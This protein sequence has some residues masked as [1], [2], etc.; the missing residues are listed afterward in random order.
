LADD[1]RLC[2][3]ASQNASGPANDQEVSSRTQKLCRFDQR[4][5]IANRNQPFTRSRQQSFDEH[6]FF[7][8]I[9]DVS[10]IRKRPRPIDTIASASF[11]TAVLAACT[12]IA[13]SL[14]ATAFPSADDIGRWGS[15][16]R[17]GN[18]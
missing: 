15:I 8:A 17:L 18:Y 14:W 9:M 6:H 5:I 4:S 13:A 11:F 3:D 2:D 10:D 1:I 12:A 7:R 16:D